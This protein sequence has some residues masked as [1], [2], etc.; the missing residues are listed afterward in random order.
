MRVSELWR[1]PVKS[2]GGE[3][4]LEADVDELGLLGDRGWG[5]FD[6][7]TGLTLTGRR[8]P[9]L[10]MASARLADGELVIT[11]PGGREVGEDDDA[12]LS[13]WLGREVALRSAADGAGRFENPMDVEREA[14]WIEWDGPAGTFHDSG[15]SRFT[16]VSTQSLREWDIRRFRTNVVVDT[17]GEDEF[18]GGVISIGSVVNG[19]FV[20]GVVATVTK[21]VDR[22]IM[23]TR[24]QPGLGADRAVL[25]TLRDERE[26]CL[27]VGCT[28]DQPGRIA[29]GSSVDRVG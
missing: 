3:S 11:L 12:V 27:S 9:E 18:V 7:E 29:L 28:V 16:L 5:V 19:V 14:D 20:D 24:P 15:R 1:Y 17:G 4:L 8:T 23:V 2:M 21:R 25:T 22:C 6:V 26:M 13:A 10:L